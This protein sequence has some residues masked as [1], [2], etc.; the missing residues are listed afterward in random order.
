MATNVWGAAIRR[1]MSAWGWNQPTMA[2]FLDVP[3]ST[4]NGWLRGRRS[5]SDAMKGEIV[6]R[7]GIHGAEVAPEW[8][9]EAIVPEV[10]PAPPTPE[11]AAS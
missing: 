6:R 10:P 3:L 4:L 8:L 5:P 7:L 9:R 11:K 1:R 2:T